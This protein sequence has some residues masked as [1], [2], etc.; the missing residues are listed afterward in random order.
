MK[1]TQPYVIAFYINHGIEARHFVLS[2]LVE[3]LEKQGNKVVF[4]F[5]N[6][7]N[8]EIS[9]EYFPDEKTIVL[10]NNIKPKNRFWIEGYVSA[11]RK[12]RLNF[13][14]VGLFHNYNDPKPPSPLRDLV[15]G[16]W[17]IH[18]LVSNFAK[19][20]YK[21]YYTDISIVHFLRS[22]EIKELFILDYNSPFQL[23]L[24]YSANAA[25]VGLHV[26]INTL[27]SFYINNFIPFDAKNI[28]VWS[29]V[30][31]S[32]FL[33]YNSNI[34]KKNT[35]VSGCFFHNFL[36]HDQNG[37]VP[38]PELMEL[39]KE[40]YVLYSLIFQTMYLEEYHLIENLEKTL[41]KLFPKNTPK[42]I[43]RRNP[44]EDSSFNLDQIKSI[45]S[46]KIAPHLWERDASKDWSI[47]S[48]LG[49]YEWKYLLSNAKILINISSMASIEA[50]LLGTPVINLGLNKD[51][52]KEVLLKRFYNAPFMSEILNSRFS[53]LALN[54]AE[55][56]HFLI[57]FIIVKEKYS[58]HE[59]QNSLKISKTDLERIS[60]IFN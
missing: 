11:V 59:V 38:S 49:E 51:G 30:Q 19:L 57:S 60:F 33:R 7:I 9:K 55:L 43:V 53:A 52:I 10:P 54:Q 58:I 25:N 2:S 41:I 26:C 14:K 27:K 23:Q 34:N 45:K 6:E 24:G 3:R 16:N 36:L 18:F 13:E 48:Q 21:W 4:L 44:F 28:Y 29:E 40:P 15:L 22:V 32:I 50:L 1:K 42:I 37:F 39:T 46:V 8:T 17:I 31:K 56:E 35:I 12:A 5:K 47:Q 20:L